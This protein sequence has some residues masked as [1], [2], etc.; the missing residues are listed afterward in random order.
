LLSQVLPPSTH[1]SGRVGQTLEAHVPHLWTGVHV[2]NFSDRQPGDIVLV[3]RASDVIGHAMQYGQ[4]LSAN[5]LMRAGNL[6]SHA[7]IYVGDGNVVDASYP[8]GVQERP[9]WDYCQ[10]RALQLRRMTDAAI[11]AAH[12][13]DIAAKARAHVGEPY[14]VIQLILAKLGWVGAQVPNPSA[15]YCSTLVSLVVTEA[16]GVD[17]SGAPQYQPLYPAVL[18]THP[19]LDDLLLEWRNF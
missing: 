15:L 8:I 18:A 17:L 16:T 1:A 4:L 7:A 12:V 14:S 11:P 3:Y 2:P 10:Y 5:Q 9:V 13:A 19:E 6:C